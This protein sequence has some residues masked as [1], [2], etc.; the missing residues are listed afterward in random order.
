MTSPRVGFT[1]VNGAQLYFE[2]RGSGP[3]LV[4][5][6]GGSVDAQHFADVAEAL[7]PDLRTITYDRRANGRSPRPDGWFGTSIAEQ[8]DDVAGL[9]EGL[10]VGPCAVWAGSLGGVILLELLIRRPGLVRTAIVQEP[11]LFCALDDGNEIAKGLSASAARAIRDN[12]VDEGFS[13]HARQSLGAAFDGLGHEARERMF[14]NARVFLGIEIPALVDYRPD[15]VGA[16]A[17]IDI[18]VHVMADPD[19]GQTPPGRAARWLAD[20]FATELRDL[21]GGH[22]PYVTQPENTAA[23]IRTLVAA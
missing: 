23:A 11:P 15:P 3:P 18:P 10:G 1:Q 21:P 8:A 6:P 7:A 17:R 20:F 12:A 4:L 5:I 16:I 13:E 2:E 9:I 14:A 22:I 19:N